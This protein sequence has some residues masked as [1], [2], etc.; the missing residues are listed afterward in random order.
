MKIDH[1]QSL[2]LIIRTERKRQGLRQ[3]DLAAAIGVGVVFLS[4]LENGKE[5]A[6]IGKVIK[7]LHGLS[8]NLEVNTR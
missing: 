2:G 6:E 1:T 5:T 3:A 8:L 4:D 7:V